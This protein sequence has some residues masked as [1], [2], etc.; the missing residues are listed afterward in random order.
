MLRRSVP[1]T[2][3]MRRV[4]PFAASVLLAAASM[5]LLIAACNPL[6]DESSVRRLPTPTALGPIVI[7]TGEPGTVEPGTT[8]LRPTRGPS[9]TPLPTRTPRPTATPTPGTPIPTNTPTRTVT[10]FPTP[11]HFPSP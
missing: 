1:P 4:G 10:P 11:T 6:P 5:I 7:E 3:S 2:Q 8:A 9:R